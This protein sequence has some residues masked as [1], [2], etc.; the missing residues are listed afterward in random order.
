MTS[1]VR[2][3]RSLLRLVCVQLALAAVAQAQVPAP[4]PQPN[5]ALS[6]A[7]EV[8]SIAYQ[9]DGSLVLVGTFTSVGG[10]SRDGLAKLRPDGSLDSQWYPRVRW[11]DGASTYAA[12][13][14]YALPDGGILVQ[15]Q[16][17]HIDGQQTLGCGVKLSSGALPVADL[18]WHTNAGGCASVYLT[19]DAQ[20]WYYYSTS[21]GVRRG[22]ADTGE[23]DMT[24]IGDGLSSAPLVY[25]G[26]GGLLRQ[27]GHGPIERVLT[28]TG[29][30]DTNWQAFGDP[31]GFLVGSVVDEGAGYIYLASSSGEISKLALLGGQSASG[32][33]K[34]L[35]HSVNALE[36]GLQGELFAAG[37]GQVTR[38]STTS[39]DVLASWPVRGHDYSVLALAR[40]SDGS[41]VAAGNFARIGQTFSMGLAQF[42]PAAQQPAS[43]VPMEQLGYAGHFAHQPFGGIVVTGRFDSAN[44][45]ERR[46]LLRLEPDGTLDENW[47][48]G[49]DGDIAALAI[50]A[51]GDIYLGGYFNGVGG[52][53]N[54]RGL[55]KIDGGVGAVRLDWSPQF[56]DRYVQGIVVDADDV[57]VSSGW[58]SPQLARLSQHDGSRTFQWDLAASGGMP[59]RLQRVGGNLYVSFSE[60][61]SVFAARRISIATTAMDPDWKLRFSSDSE[62]SIVGADGGDLFVGG[63]FTSINDVSRTHLARVS[64]TLPVQVRDWNPAPNGAVYGLGRTGDDR[65]FASGA[66]TTIGGK[67]RNGVAE[68]QSSDGVALDSW[69]PRLGG[70][71]LLLIQDRIYLGSVRRGVAGYPL[72]IGDVIFATQ[73][74]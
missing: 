49:I 70:G 9:P 67:S 11:T 6:L 41:V 57:Y 7:G 71:R 20:G 46:R 51:G 25:D 15:G 45:V 66:F 61:N 14:V 58:S 62:L 56:D 44:G 42:F 40:R 59:V 31:K 34:Q 35:S 54:Y 5:L 55:V 29:A 28:T 39:G 1:S 73:F 17:S 23:L 8:S 43:L 47:T 22:R 32:W 27:T 33:P 48:L 38:L 60:E 63:Y 52:Y 10:V 2:F 16:L 65:L 36:R 3:F 24:W 72:D 68:L 19:F 69:M 37:L 4:L 50:D 21:S 30:L 26:H 18:T 74:E 12:R 53:S 13:R 64:S